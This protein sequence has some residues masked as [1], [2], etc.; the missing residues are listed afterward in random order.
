MKRHD[1]G[2]RIEETYGKSR[3]GNG[4]SVT[5]EDETGTK[6]TKEAEIHSITEEEAENSIS[7]QTDRSSRPTDKYE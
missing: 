7:N 2:A 4:S 6:G 3:K 5:N 1:K